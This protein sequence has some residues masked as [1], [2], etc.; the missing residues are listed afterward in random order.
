MHQIFDFYVG[1]LSFIF[2]GFKIF[3]DLFFL[4]VYMV[5]THEW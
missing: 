2:K 5:S 4:L 1:K 3:E